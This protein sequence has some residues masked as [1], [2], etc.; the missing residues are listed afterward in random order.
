MAAR[1]IAPGE[2]LLLE[3]EPDA[4]FLSWDKAATNCQHCCGAIQ[5]QREDRMMMMNGII[6]LL[7]QV[8]ASS[9][10]M[11]HKKSPTN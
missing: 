4:W 3:S 5:K 8:Q 9:S 10:I 7:F 6:D 1:D 2:I 11:C